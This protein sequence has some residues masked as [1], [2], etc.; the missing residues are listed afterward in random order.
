MY[1]LLYVMKDGTEIK[2]SVDNNGISFCAI[3]HADVL[4]DQSP[5]KYRPEDDSELLKPGTKAK[6][7]M[8]C[9]RNCSLEIVSNHGF[10]DYE[11][12]LL[13]NYIAIHQ[14][15]YIEKAQCMDRVERAIGTI[16]DGL[17]C[18]NSEFLARYIT[19]LV[20]YDVNEITGAEYIRKCQKIAHLLAI[21]P[22]LRANQMIRDA[23]YV[24]KETFQDMADSF[25]DCVFAVD[26]IFAQI[27]I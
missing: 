15:E 11:S 14:E 12:A 16:N 23:Y 4:L 17:L 26:Q 18:S 27:T 2:G 25:W 1:H 22:N 6:V 3:R 20:L 8:L 9:H 5:L 7:I 13:C 19:K 24:F 21:S 10:N